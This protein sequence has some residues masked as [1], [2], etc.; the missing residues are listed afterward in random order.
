MA[1]VLSQVESAIIS[2]GQVQ[3]QVD[4]VFPLTMAGKAHELA[5]AGL[6]GKAILAI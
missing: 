6:V 3:L 5:E 1:V 2:T 4:E